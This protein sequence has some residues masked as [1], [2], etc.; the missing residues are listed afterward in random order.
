MDLA[1][2]L[3]GTMTTPTIVGIMT[4]EISTLPH[5]AVCATKQVSLQTATIPADTPAMASVMNQP[6]VL[7]GRTHQIV[8][9]ILPEEIRGILGVLLACIRVIPL[10]EDIIPRSTPLAVTCQTA[11]VL[12][13][14]ILLEEIRRILDMIVQTACIGSQEPFQDVSRDADDPPR[15]A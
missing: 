15:A 10:I 1:R 7:S 9:A 13:K 12:P 6:T 11:V 2:A 5:N 8:E 4:T 3:A 14:A